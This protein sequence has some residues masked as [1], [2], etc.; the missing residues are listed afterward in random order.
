MLAAV[1]E[2]AAE[3]VQRAVVDAVLQATAVA[4]IPAYRDVFP[5]AFT[6]GIPTSR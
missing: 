4:G 6:A 2:A 3:V 5:S 1:C